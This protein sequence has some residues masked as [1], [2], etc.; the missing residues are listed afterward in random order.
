[1][2]WRDLCVFYLLCIGQPEL[3]YND[4]RR[5][6]CGSGP[7]YIHLRHPRGQLCGK[8]NRTAF[9]ELVI[10]SLLHKAVF[11][12]LKAGLEIGEMILAVN[13]DS[14]VGSNYDTVSR[15]NIVVKGTLNSTKLLLRSLRVWWINWE[16]KWL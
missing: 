14:L 4:N 9:L 1:M 11:F 16:G 13:K 5:Q 8:G 15:M 7:R 3:R 12:P 10:V 6:A 2:G